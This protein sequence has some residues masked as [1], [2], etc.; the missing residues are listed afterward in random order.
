MITAQLAIVGLEFLHLQAIADNATTT[1]ALSSPGGQS[2]SRDV[3]NEVITRLWTP[4][5]GVDHPTWTLAPG[6]VSLTLTAELPQSADPILRVL[7][8][9]SL[10]VHAQQALEV[11]T[12]QS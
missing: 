9:T 6:S 4:S 11:S 1:A 8:V 12:A 5:L 2:A 7:G 3:A 10:T